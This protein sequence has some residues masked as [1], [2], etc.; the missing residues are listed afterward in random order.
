MAVIGENPLTWATNKPGWVTLHA[1]EF[2]TLVVITQ[3]LKHHEIEEIE[4]EVVKGEEK[5]KFYK[6]LVD[7]LG[8]AYE[9]LNVARVSGW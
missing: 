1:D 2:E 6:V 9:L 5:Q 4:V 7:N 8:L 3:S